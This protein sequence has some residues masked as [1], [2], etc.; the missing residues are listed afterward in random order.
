MMP[1][2]ITCS[3]FAIHQHMWLA[4]GAMVQMVVH[5]VHAACLMFMVH[6]STIIY[7]FSFLPHTNTCD[8]GANIYGCYR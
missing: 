3:P 4:L 1:A 2:S 7:M 8:H 5:V 6:D